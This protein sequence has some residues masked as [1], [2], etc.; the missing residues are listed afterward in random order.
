MADQTTFEVP[1]N[2][3]QMPFID[4][5]EIGR[6]YAVEIIAAEL[7]QL[8]PVGRRNAFTRIRIVRAALKEQLRIACYRRKLQREGRRSR[9]PRP[10]VERL[11]AMFGVP[12]RTLV[13]W[14]AIHRRAGVLGL[15]PENRGRPRGGRSTGHTAR[16]SYVADAVAEVIVSMLAS[17]EARSIAQAFGRVK[18]ANPLVMRWPALRTIESRVKR[19]RDCRSYLAMPAASRN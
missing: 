18:A 16:H 11:A 4:A 12:V 7:K 13:R 15:I 3:A 5:G 6:A 10:S 1:S 17:N 2:A 14:L 9:L 19:L 8:S